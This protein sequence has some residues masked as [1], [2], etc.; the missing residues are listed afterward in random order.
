VGDLWLESGDDRSL[1]SFTVFSFLVGSVVFAV[2]ACDCEWVAAAVEAVVLPGAV[3]EVGGEG[4]FDLVRMRSCRG[5]FILFFGE[6]TGKDGIL[7]LR[8]IPDL[9]ILLVSPHNRCIG[10]GRRTMQF[11][12]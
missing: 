9:E 4:D 7:L 2:G 10:G 11:D 8:L 3:D 1:F 5:T 6:R 12:L